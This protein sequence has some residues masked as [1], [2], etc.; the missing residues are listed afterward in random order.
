MDLHAF[1]MCSTPLLIVDCVCRSSYHQ[2]TTT[3]SAY[4]T[5]PRMTAKNIRIQKLICNTVF[6][7]C[8]NVITVI[9][10]DICSQYNRYSVCRLPSGRIMA[11]NI[12]TELCVAERANGLGG[13]SGVS[14]G[15]YN[16]TRQNVTNILL[17]SG[18]LVWT[19]CCIISASR[20]QDISESRSVAS[21]RIGTVCMVE[22]N[23]VYASTDITAS[24]VNVHYHP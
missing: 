8:I 14:F 10:V 23:H 3:S 9:L 13:S 18:C 16:A 1:N 11:V 20:F 15:V 21:S 12:L 2:P 5:I 19:S 17:F 4:M 6:V 22:V 24:Q 7:I